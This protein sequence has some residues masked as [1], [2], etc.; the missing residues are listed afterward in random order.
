MPGV[1]NGYGCEAHVIDC[2]FPVRSTDAGAHRTL[3]KLTAKRGSPM[4]TCRRCLGLPNRRGA[5]SI[6]GLS[7]PSSLGLGVADVGLLPRLVKRLP[8]A[9][10]VVSIQKIEQEFTDETADSSTVSA[11]LC[12]TYC[13]RATRDRVNRGEYRTTDL[14]VPAQNPIRYGGDFA[15]GLTSQRCQQHRGSVENSGAGR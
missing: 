15:S 12:V 2:L 11:Q 7:V 14:V 8:A 6:G 5:S 13:L 9:R 1:S 10:S 3:V 4:S